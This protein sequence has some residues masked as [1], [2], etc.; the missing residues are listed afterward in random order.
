MSGPLQP[1]VQ[2]AASSH[3]EPYAL[4]PRQTSSRS[5][6]SVCASSCGRTWQACYRPMH[7]PHLAALRSSERAFMT[8]G[9]DRVS[10][11]PTRSQTLRS[12]SLE[13]LHLA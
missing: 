4:A 11:R 1:S 6:C 10:R 7:A 3:D 12:H 2:M 5:P 13:P 8:L 9:N